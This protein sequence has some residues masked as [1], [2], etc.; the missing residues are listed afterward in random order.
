MEENLRVLSLFSGI[1]AFEKALTNI[2]INYELVG[3]SEI[4]KYAINSYCAIHGVSNK[5][6]IG[7][8]TKVDTDSIT[9]F[10][11]LVGGSPCQNISIMRKTTVDNRI[12]E[13][14]QGE[15]SRLFFDYVRILND[16]LPKYFVFENVRNLLYS[17][18]GEDFK[19]V[20]ELLGENY[21]IHHKLI[22]SCDY[23][24]PQVRRRLF[25]VGQRKDL[26][27]FNYEFPKQIKLELTAQ[28][29]LEKSVDDKYYL[30][31]KMYKTV[32]ST[33]TKGWY[34]KPETDC[35]IAKPLVRT[36]HKMHRA[37]TDNYYHTEYKPNDKTNLR[38]LT[39]LE[40]FRLQGFSDED[41]MRVKNIKIS[42]TQMY[43]QTGNSITV[44]VLECIL[45]NLLLS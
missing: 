3:F 27:E 29:L 42:D 18:N 15:E 16:K 8:V 4:D 12:P 38:R 1:G 32:M 7:D 21:N 34:A 40:C 39:P 45:K 43:M 26:G 19:T 11:L 44:T 20:V 10:D 24:I 41:Y 23:G 36:M 9:E 2:G 13:G 31:D 33:G 5:L 14:L 25:I 17:N 30:T 28:E 6:N 22:N 35:K 37:S